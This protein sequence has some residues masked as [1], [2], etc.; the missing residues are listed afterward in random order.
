MRYSTDVRVSSLEISSYMV[1]KGSKYSPF[2][3]KLGNMI[4]HK[5]HQREP[6]SKELFKNRTMTI[7]GLQ[8]A[9]RDSA[10]IAVNTEHVAITSE[11]DH[12]LHQVGLA[13]FQTPRQ[14]GST[15]LSTSQP[16]LQDFYVK[17]QIQA[18]TLNINISMPARRSHRFGQEQQVGI[19]NLE[20]AI[21][22][23]IKSCNNKAH[24]LLIGFEMAAEWAYLPRFS[25]QAISFFLAWVDLRDIAKDITSSVRVIP[26]LTSLLQIFGYHWKD[27]QPGK[28]NL[29]G[30]MTDNDGDDAV[31]TCAL[32]NALLFS[33]N[34]E[35]LRF[36]QECGQI[37][38]I[39][40][41]KKGS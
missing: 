12:I 19:G 35:K 16:C 20:A 39:F 38:H 14:Q 37:A 33:E 29:H 36:R 21:I 34:H 41:R 11:K 26:G 25:P 24:L 9:P 27:I 18:L 13:Y 15:S 30:C 28:K 5:Q 40:T 22:D 8:N 23:F 31:A 32:A 3:L 4:T 17:N 1:E 2:A 10:F 6:T 7:Q